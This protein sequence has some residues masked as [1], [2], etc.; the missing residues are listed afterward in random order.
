[1]AAEIGAEWRGRLG[2][3]PAL[4]EQRARRE[5]RIAGAVGDVLWLLEHDPVV[6]TGRRAV[7]A[8]G[9]VTVPIV[10]TERGGLAT[11]H[12]PGQLVGYLIADVTTHGQGVKS[13]I[14]A[15]EE[16][17]IRWLARRGIAAGRAAGRPGVWVG[18]DKVAAIG[19]HFRRGVSMHGF[20]LNLTVDLRHFDEFVPC[21]LADA[22][23]TSV[24]RLAGDCP[25]P[26]QAWESV[27]DDVIA[28]LG[29]RR[30]R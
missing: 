16:G 10:E 30:A 2:Y 29:A 9:R 7:E 8:L 19:M 23:V 17:L 20:A 5:A 24:A 14:A 6:T 27:A 18:G 11:F 15:V 26:E 1:M 28:A 4:A 12:G 3:S 22:G 13:T 25:T 21:G